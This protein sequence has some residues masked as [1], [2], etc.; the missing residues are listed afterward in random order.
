MYSTAKGTKTVSVITSCRILSCESDIWLYP[1]RLAGTWSRYSN[2]AI[3]QLASAATYHLRSP[4]FRKWAYQAKVMKTFD[5]TRSRAVRVK[6][7]GIGGVEESG[8]RANGRTGERANGR[9]GEQANRRTGER[10]NGEPT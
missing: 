7:D 4:R 10:A 8:E 3:P 2:R 6:T 1:I 5:A 9:T